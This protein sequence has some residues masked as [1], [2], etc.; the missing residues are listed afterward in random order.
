MAETKLHLSPLTLKLI[1]KDARMPQPKIIAPAGTY[2]TEE[3]VSVC[4]LLAIDPEDIMPRDLT[5]FQDVGNKVS[6]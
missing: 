4:T 1:F 6:N 5:E 2:M 3:A